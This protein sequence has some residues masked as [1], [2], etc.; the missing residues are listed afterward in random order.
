MFNF[1]TKIFIGR[2][3]ALWGNDEDVMSFFLA[4]LQ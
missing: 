3:L 4:V 2:P 1:V